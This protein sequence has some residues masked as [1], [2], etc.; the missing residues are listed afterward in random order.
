[1]LAQTIL[2]L[3][4][5]RQ[6]NDQPTVGVIAIEILVGLVGI[7]SSIYSYSHVTGTVAHR[8]LVYLIL[9][10]VVIVASL[11]SLRASHKSFTYYCGCNFVVF[12]IDLIFMLVVPYT[13]YKYSGMIFVYSV[14]YY[15][16]PAYMVACTVMF[17]K[18][19][20]QMRGII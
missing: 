13:H 15:T 8:H 3:R 14:A 11:A 9:C 2:G 19:I 10:Y 17:C 12:A 16:F 20:S 18:L 6:E 5:K 1:M 7:V 4:R